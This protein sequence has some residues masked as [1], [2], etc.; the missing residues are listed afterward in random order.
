MATTNA[1]LIDQ[2]MSRLGQRKSTRVRSDIVSEINTA[3]NT[4]ERG[5]FHPWF[6][7]ETATLSVVSGESFKVLPTDYLIEADDSRPYFIESGTT[8]FLTKRFYGVLMG[9]TPPELRF[10]AIRGEEFHFRMVADK[11][12]TIYVPYYAKQTG[13]LVDDDTVVSNKWLIE[14]FDWTISEALKVVASVHLHSTEL[15]Q[16][17]A[18]IALRA[19]RDIFKHH[20]ARVNKNQDFEVGGATDGS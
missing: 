7:E 10:Y 15:A 8:Y 20:E 5:D 19:K 11:A 9:E 14:A 17:H 2:A 18:A 12:Y 6:L 13:N 4:L 3:I 16:T 1:Q